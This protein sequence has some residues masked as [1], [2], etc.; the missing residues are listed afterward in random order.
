M[1]LQHSLEILTLEG[2]SDIMDAV[3]VKHPWAWVY[4]VSF[5]IMTSFILFNLFIAVIISKMQKEHEDK[6]DEK[7]DLILEKVI[8]LEKR[9]KENNK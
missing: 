8:A 1:Y 2:W 5:I 6:E 9:F 7:I 3:M 4:F